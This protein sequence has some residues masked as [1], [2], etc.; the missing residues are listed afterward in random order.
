MTQTRLS[1]LTRLNPA[2]PR[3]YLFALAGGLWTVA[4]VMLCLRAEAWLEVF[5]L[6]TEI[7][8]A[9]LCVALAAVGYLFLFM[10]IVR[11]NIDRI[12]GLPER[13]CLFAFTAWRGYGLI[14]LMILLGMTLRDTTFPKY[15]LAIP[16]TVM[17]IILIIGSVRFY[18][19][20]LV[21]RT[22]LR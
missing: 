11:K 10:H 4:G 15:L 17:G 3:H 12:A 16:Y 9:A 14:T 20:F 8:L 6:G 18:R 13:A 7:G 19:Q 22:A 2:I 1:L 21:A 5:P